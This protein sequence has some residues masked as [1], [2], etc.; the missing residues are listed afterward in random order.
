MQREDVRLRPSW[1]LCGQQTLYML[2]EN[3]NDRSVIGTT[4]S[5][6]TQE[7]VSKRLWYRSMLNLIQDCMQVFIDGMYGI[8]VSTIISFILQI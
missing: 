5:K 8:F 4:K 6:V 7:V 1:S 3:F 2:I